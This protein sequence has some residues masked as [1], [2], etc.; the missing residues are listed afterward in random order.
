[1]NITIL[2]DYANAVRGLPC[3]SS[4]AGHDV[5]V[6][7]DYVRDQGVLAERLRDTDILVLLRER[8]AIRAPLIERLPRLKMISQRNVYPHIDVEAC[9]RRGIIVAT[10]TPPESAF[11]AASELTWGLIIAA[12]RRIPQE[13]A[14]LKGG[15]WQS[16]AGRDL[17]GGTLGIFGYGRIG[18][19]LAG[20]GKAF[21]MHVLAWGREGSA[22]R[23]RA[24]GLAFAAGREALFE[25]SDVLA[26]TV[27]LD[28]GSAGIVTGKDLSRMKPTS[29]FVNTSRAALIERGALA[30]ALKAG[31]PGMA[32]VD[33]F[34]DEPVLDARDPL[35]ALDSV[36]CT[37]HLG[38]VTL[39]NLN[40]YYTYAFDQITAYL[41]G[42]PTNVVN[43]E[44][45]KNAR[46]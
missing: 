30:A 8:T 32:A 1:M 45:L 12:M 10:T 3:F 40:S 22:E 23:A 24:D 35:L 34:D 39:A 38:Y 21:G 43:P 2:D 25:Q 14:A 27:R 5:T 28:P 31:R 37:P 26:V 44:A 4:L 7:N 36:V 11:H 19:M 6:W 33:V 41:A 42:A 16:S 17:R 18:A 9:T 15:R 46:H 29:L 20:Y 13:M